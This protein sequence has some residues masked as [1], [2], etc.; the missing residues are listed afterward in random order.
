MS[1]LL[2]PSKLRPISEHNLP[3]PLAVDLP[4]DNS[5]RPPCRHLADDIAEIENLVADLICIDDFRAVTDEGLGRAGFAGPNTPQQ[6]H[7]TPGH[8]SQTVPLPG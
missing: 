5:R 2:Q 4:V 7:I 6:H 8:T 3:E 1:D